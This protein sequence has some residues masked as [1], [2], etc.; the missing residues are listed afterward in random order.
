MCI[1]KPSCCV[2]ST[3]VNSVFRPSGV[4][5]LSTSWFAGVTVGHVDLC[6]VAGK[7]L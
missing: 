2:T 6:R 4:G 1:G 5:R 7:T 3:K